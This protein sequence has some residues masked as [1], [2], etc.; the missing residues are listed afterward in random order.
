MFLCLNLYL[1]AS[2]LH[3]VP[4]NTST[5]QTTERVGTKILISQ[6]IH[7]GHKTYKKINFKILKIYKWNYFGDINAKAF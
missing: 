4:M 7:N 3:L 2:T 1:L 5:I 6:K